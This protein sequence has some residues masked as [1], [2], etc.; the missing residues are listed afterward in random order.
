M[1]EQQED[2][3]HTALRTISHNTEQ[4]NGKTRYHHKCVK[5]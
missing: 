1:H 2:E 5:N 3:R 4:V